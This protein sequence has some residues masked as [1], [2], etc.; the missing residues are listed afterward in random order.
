MP[1]A[2]LYQFRSPGES[3]MPDAQG[4]F[5][6]SDFVADL[7]Q[8]GF[9]AFSPD[10]LITIVNR[11]YFAVAK[12]S[13]WEWEK[14]KATF[15][16]NPGQFSVTVTCVSTSILPNFRSLDRLYMTDAGYERKLNI[17]AEEDFVRN[18]LSL[19]LT[20]PQ[21]R[22]DPTSYFIYDELL[23]ILN[24]PMQTRS[25]LAY[26]FQMPSWIKDD[27]DHFV[28]PQHLDE[29]IINAARVRAHTRANELVLA[30]SARADLEE[31]FDDMRDDEEEDAHEYQERTSPDNTWL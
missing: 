20:A 12:K 30:T 10:E 9:D 28:T 5:Y 1:H 18:Y 2:Y 25:F 23:Y 24:P 4:K 26:Y 21:Y 19:D 3:K 31:S 11:A 8:R 6:L 14:T 13:R 17:M 29:A 27:F 15:T 16:L 7:Q 22:Q